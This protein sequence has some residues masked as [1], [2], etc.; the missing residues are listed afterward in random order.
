MTLLI[1][2]QVI[3]GFVLLVAGAELLVRGA[4]RIASAMGVTPLV[5]GL[6]IVAYGTSAPEMA[7]SVGAALRGAAD[8]SLGNVVGSNIFN[9]LLILGA[10]A[11]VAPLSVHQKLIRID[12]PLL[13]GVSCVSA[14]MAWNGNVG[15]FEG[16]VLGLGAIAYTVFAI[17][18]SRRETRSIAEEYEQEFGARPEAQGTLRNVLLILAGLACLVGGSDL[19]VRGSIQIAKSLGVSQLVIGLTIVAGGTSLPELATSVVAALKGERDIAVG[20]IIGSNLFNLL[21]VLGFSSAFSSSGVGVARAAIEFDIPVMIIASIL[22]LPIVF[23]DGVISRIEGAFL[24]TSYALYVV[25][26][27]LRAMEHPALGRF[28]VVA[29]VAMIPIGLWVLV[30]PLLRQRRETQ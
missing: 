27:I 30:A 5:I 15:R 25:Y 11:L 19:L 21:A 13:I 1:L 29:M 2:A 16:T 23:N 28:S 10:S 20:N 9:T 17:L 14:L 12:I 3:G 8:V 18:E 24:L 4:S 26:L 6:T 22:C 7:V